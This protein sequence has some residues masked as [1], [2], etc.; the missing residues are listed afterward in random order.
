MTPRLIF[1]F[2]VPIE[3]IG[4]N[5]IEVP[6]TEND[7]G[8]FVINPERFASEGSKAFHSIAENEGMS[9]NEF[10]ALWEAV[11]PVLG[12]EI[13]KLNFGRLI[14]GSRIDY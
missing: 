12:S 5:A 3:Q 2:K 4:N 6:L 10:I 8:N 7:S 13:A 1:E 9:P 11:L 14:E